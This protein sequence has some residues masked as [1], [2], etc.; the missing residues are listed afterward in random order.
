MP[1]RAD[2]Q[3]VGDAEMIPEELVQRRVFV[4]PDDFVDRYDGISVDGGFDKKMLCDEHVLR[5]ELRQCCKLL[6]RLLQKLFRI[7]K[8]RQVLTGRRKQRKIDICNEK[9]QTDKRIAGCREKQGVKDG[10][11]DQIIVR[12]TQEILRDLVVDTVFRPVQILREMIQQNLVI[13]GAMYDFGEYRC[14]VDRGKPLLAGVGRKQDNDA[15]VLAH[16]VVI[17]AGHVPEKTLGV[18]GEIQIGQFDGNI[19]DVLPVGAFQCFRIPQRIG[20]QRCGQGEKH[21]EKNKEKQVQNRRFQ[22]AF[23]ERLYIFCDIMFVVFGHK[24]MKSF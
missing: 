12:L 8:E 13:F 20:K 21:P 22:P 11:S 16:G 2:V 18:A 7:A 1:I 3:R 19:F 24:Y 4:D 5:R 14:V 9:D 15:F 6:L 23:V 10:I 17:I